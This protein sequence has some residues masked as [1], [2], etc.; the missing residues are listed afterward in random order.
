MRRILMEPFLVSPLLWYVSLLYRRKETDG[1]VET[2]QSAFPDVPL[3]NIVYHLSKTRSAQATSEE[4][5]ERGFLPS[6][7]LISYIIRIG[8]DISP[9]V[10]IRSHH[11]SPHHLCQ[12]HR[13]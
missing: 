1:Q 11:H 2:I 10:D 6:V 13:R 5:L 4:I 7:R 9:Q 3:A 8:P 12:M